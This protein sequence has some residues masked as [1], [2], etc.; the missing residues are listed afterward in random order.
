VRARTAQWVAGSVAACSIAL[1][2]GG[3][4]L[5]YVDRHALP[6]DLT[7]WNFTDVF[8]DV[9]NMAVP[10]LG[11]VLASR[12]PANRMGWLF[13]V[14][15]LALALGGF[16]GPYGLHALRVAPGSLPAGRLVAWL[17]NWIF[18]VQAAMLAFLLLLFPTGRLR[19]RRWRPAAWFVAGVYTSVGLVLIIRATRFW[20]HPFPTFPNGLYQWVAIAIVILLP[21]TYVI[22]VAAVVVRFA[23]SSGEER[24]QLKWFAAAALLVVAATIPGIVTNSSAANVL[25]NLAFLCLYAAIGVAVLKYR[26]YEID[27]VISKAVL[28]G[29]LAVF[30]TA[31][32]AA[33]VVGVG[34]LAGN[35][36]SPLLAALA[37]AVVALAFQPVRQWAGR[38]ANRVVYGRRATP[39]QVLSDFARRIGGAY[40]DEDVLPQMAQIVAAGT[41]AERV[42]V[43][44]RVNDELRPEASAGGKLRPESSPDGAPGMAPLPVHGQAMPALPDA[45]MSVPVV[46]QGDLLGAISIKMPRD[47]PLR[48]AGEQLVTDVASQAGLVLSNVGLIEDLRASRQRLVAAQDETRRRLERNIHDGA[49]QDLVALAIKLRLAETTVNEEPARQM[50]GELQADAAGALEN[51]RDLARGIYPPLLADLGLVA[52]LSAQ[53]SKSPVPVA[54]DADG[55][56]RFGQATEAAVYFCCLEALQNITKYAHA[57][58]ARIC[59]EA[60]NGTLRFI[61][62]DDGAGYD[63]H[64]TPLGS[65]QRNMADRLA[66]LGG[67]LE[68][69]SAPGQGTVITAQVPS[70]PANLTGTSEARW[71]APAR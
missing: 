46:H 27:V 52:A 8:T 58:Q 53:A 9:V 38:L 25:Q 21:A 49:Q 7:N 11:F 54:V 64:H 39:Y 17:A 5:A 45:G 22:S 42:V 31:V 67:Q 55:I 43:W 10:V 48:P 57:T 19:S 47:E 66:A 14:A 6:A 50:L 1:M 3:M 69:R 65:G 23:L 56:G 15:G 2:T 34:T 51:L 70:T 62:S 68:V 40:A 61:V 36:R 4:V 41:G 35:R 24:L 32:Y 33:L 26:L 16:T 37:A 12:R 20:A 71:A 63:A 59:L 18:V 13:L 60:Q 30:I 28:Y 44:L 29:S